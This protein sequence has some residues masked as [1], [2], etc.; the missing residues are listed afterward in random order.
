MAWKFLNPK[1]WK[2]LNQLNSLEL[3]QV[4]SQNIE[5]SK[6][7]PRMEGMCKKKKSLPVGYTEGY[8]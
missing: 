2:I 5:L 1:Q 7:M 3:I 8:L 6:H 4:G